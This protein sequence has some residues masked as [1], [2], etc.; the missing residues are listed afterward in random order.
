M[1]KALSKI[2][3]KN[4]LLRRLNYDYGIFIG[5]THIKYY[6]YMERRY[7]SILLLHYLPCIQALNR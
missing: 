3:A 4:F 1:R 7:D 2:N 6:Y 5:N